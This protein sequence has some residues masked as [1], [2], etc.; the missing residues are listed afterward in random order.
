MTAVRA[1]AVGA[2]TEERSHRAARTTHKRAANESLRRGLGQL[3]PDEPIPFLC[4]CHRAGC[5][6][7]V[8]L[9]TADYDE[10]RRD[11]EWRATARRHDA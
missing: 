10:R 5:L 2:P 3:E 6:D 4:E 11:P 7:I 1:E 9:S 8:W